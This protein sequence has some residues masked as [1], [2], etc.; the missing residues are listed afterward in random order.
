MRGD[1]SLAD[2]SLVISGLIHALHWE[3]L[4][5]TSLGVFIGLVVGALPGLTTTMGVAV[6]VPVTFGM[7]PSA[8]LLDRKS[9]V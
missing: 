2:I 7:S 4:L 3:N 9:V 6:L 8:G 1:I 5:V